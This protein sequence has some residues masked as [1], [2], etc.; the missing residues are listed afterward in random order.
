MGDEDRAQG[1]QLMA[2]T[3][4]REYMKTRSAPEIA[5]RAG[6]APIEQLSEQARTMVKDNLVTSTAKAKRAK[7]PQ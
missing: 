7:P 2:R 1:F 3:V 5:E 4:W 6:L